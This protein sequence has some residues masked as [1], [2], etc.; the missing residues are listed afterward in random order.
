MIKRVLTLTAVI[1]SLAFPTGALADTTVTTST[2]VTTGSTTYTIS[3]S[4]STDQ[5]VGTVSDPQWNGY[6]W[7]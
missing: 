7:D 4:T 5:L 2:S 3:D 6:S 1:F